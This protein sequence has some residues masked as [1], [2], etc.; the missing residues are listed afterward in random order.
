M[1]D[2]WSRIVRVAGRNVNLCTTCQG[3]ARGGDQVL[4][5]HLHELKQAGVGDVSDDLLDRI[6]P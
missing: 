3:A 5:D 1:L 2:T 6:D 4:A